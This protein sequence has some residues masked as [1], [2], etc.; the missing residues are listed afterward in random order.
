MR[1][2]CGLV[3]KN[4][5][6]MLKGRIRPKP[7]PDIQITGAARGLKSCIPGATLDTDQ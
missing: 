2:R 4:K 6:N 3:F 1:T 7:Y 5:N